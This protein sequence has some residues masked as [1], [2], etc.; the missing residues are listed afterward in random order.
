MS[1]AGHV[2]D[3]INRMKANQ[4]LAKPHRANFRKVREAYINAVDKKTAL[5]FNTRKLSNSELNN[6]KERIREELKSERRKELFFFYSMTVLVFLV[7][8]LL[9]KVLI[10]DRFFSRIH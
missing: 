1:F 2:I 5:H 9:A 4:A 6:I 7:L 3:M 10:L 8:L